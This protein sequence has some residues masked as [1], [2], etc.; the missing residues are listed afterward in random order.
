MLVSSA[1]SAHFH[2]VGEILPGL[3]RPGTVSSY[4]IKNPKKLWKNLMCGPLRPRAGRQADGSFEVLACESD[5]KLKE[6]QYRED[7]I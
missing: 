4:N 7:M 3:I 6:M 5:R 2:V 1:I